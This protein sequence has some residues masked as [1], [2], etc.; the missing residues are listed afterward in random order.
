MGKKRRIRK[1]PQ[2]FGKKF[3][4]HPYMRALA[5]LEKVKEEAM[6]DG[7]IT[8]EEAVEIKKAEIEVERL[9]PPEPVEKE[10]VPEVQE[11]IQPIAEEPPV[12]KPKPAPKRKPRARKAPAAKRK[13]RKP[14][15]P[16]KLEVTE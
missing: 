13:P 1:F 2:K 3:A 15:A 5:K 6:A 14:R 8:K 10:I 4:S 9:M 12:P 7:I 11:E 16:K